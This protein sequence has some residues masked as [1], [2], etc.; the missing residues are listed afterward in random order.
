VNTVTRWIP[1]DSEAIEHPQGLGVVYAYGR[2][3]SEKIC[4]IAYK[5]KAGR[6]SWHYSFQRRARLEEHMREWFASLSGWQQR[7]AERKAQ[8][9]QPHTLKTGDVVYNSWGWEQTNIDWYQVVKTTAHFV[10]LRRIAADVRETSFMSGPSVPKPGQFVSEEVTKHKASHGQYGG[11]IHFKYGAGG[12]WDG[13]PMQCS[14]Y[15]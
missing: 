13:R 2:N 15:A 6:S 4:G 12:K 3:G 14:W 11:S 5:G 7:M 9:S 10:W 8:A 1:K